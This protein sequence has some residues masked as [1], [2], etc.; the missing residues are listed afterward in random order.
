[1]QE[2]SIT[3]L[4]PGL[5]L[6]H[7]AVTPFAHAIGKF[8]EPA[9]GGG[10][11]QEARRFLCKLDPYETA[12]ITARV[13]I[14]A[15]AETQTVQSVAIQ[16]T[17]QLVDHLEFLKFKEAMPNYVNAIIDGLNHRT[18]N[19]HYRRVNILMAKRKAGIPDSPEMTAVK[20]CI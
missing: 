20:S 19:E 5:A 18:T 3:D 13:L 17:N 4:P 10:R 11:L 12:Y 16:I 6:L 1:M 2:A 7:Q 8:I 15:L 14:N 9:P